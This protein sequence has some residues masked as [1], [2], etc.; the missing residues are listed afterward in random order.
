MAQSAQ[1][2]AIS[3]QQTVDRFDFGI[4]QDAIRACENVH[5]AFHPNLSADVVEQAP[6]LRA[7]KSRDRPD[8]V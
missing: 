5:S 4:L 6:A 2:Y 3:K 7:L 1:A 8:L